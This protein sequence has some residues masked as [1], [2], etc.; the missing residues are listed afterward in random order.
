MGAVSHSP[1]CHQTHRPR[2]RPVKT[3]GEDAADCP[4]HSVYRIVVN[5]TMFIS[6]P[7]ATAFHFSARPQLLQAAAEI[8]MCSKA[9]GT[10]EKTLQLFFSIN[11]NVRGPFQLRRRRNFSLLREKLIGEYRKTVTPAHLHL[12]ALVGTSAQSLQ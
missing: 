9:F 10:C 11:L 8:C 7:K 5:E 1:T 6:E 2:L 4:F 12:V 3:P